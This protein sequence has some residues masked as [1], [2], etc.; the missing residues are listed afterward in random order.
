MAVDIAIGRIQTYPDLSSLARS[1][2]P[3]GQ[4][5]GCNDTDLGLER[6]E[7]KRMVISHILEGQEGLAIELLDSYVEFLRGRSWD[8]LVNG[9]VDLFTGIKNTFRSAEIISFA[10]FFSLRSR[11]A[12]FEWAQETIR[13]VTRLV[14]E[15]APGN[16]L[17]LIERAKRYIQS[18]YSEDILLS[19]VAG[20][21]NLSPVYFSR[22]FK[23]QTGDNFSD[24]LIGCRIERARQLLR[25]TD[26]KVYEICEDVGYSDLKHFY[27]VFK[28]HAGC[29]PSE[30]R[31]GR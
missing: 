18:H 13:A 2:E 10:D 12:V 3:I 20:Y 29:T 6:E 5:G 1:T 19:H 26:R 7:R 25:D 31:H 17:T 27:G 11:E 14:Q 30:Y 24:Y 23:E 16:R 8:S 4:A 28:R 22:L 15:E 21:V 9:L